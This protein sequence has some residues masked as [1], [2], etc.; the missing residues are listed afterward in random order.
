MLCMEKENYI[1]KNV[2]SVFQIVRY[3]N[4]KMHVKHFIYGNETNIPET[5]FLC[6]FQCFKSKTLKT[7]LL[8]IIAI[9]YCNTNHHYE[10][11]VFLKSL[12]FAIQIIV[13]FFQVLTNQNAKTHAKHPLWRNRII[14]PTTCIF[15]VFELVIYEN[16]K[17]HAKSPI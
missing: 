13:F 12:F 11:P 14:L 7:T 3:Q 6:F 15:N 8:H 9:H 1:I 17:M 16:G 2:S 4:A 5:I 10:K